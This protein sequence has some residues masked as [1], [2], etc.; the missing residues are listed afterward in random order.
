MSKEEI[1]LCPVGE[2]LDMTA[3]A[4]IIEGNATQ[5]IEGSVDDLMKLR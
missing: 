3:W 2:I 1:L 4:A 5:Q